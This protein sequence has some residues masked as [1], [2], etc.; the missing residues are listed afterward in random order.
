MLALELVHPGT[1]EPDAAEAARV[2]RACA[3]QGVLVL[4]CGTWGNVLRLLPPLV[5]DD[6]LLDDALDVLETAL[7][8]GGE[9]AP[10]P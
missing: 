3:A 9:A 8:A 7:A 6:E 10:R 5:I 4:T 1:L 2:T